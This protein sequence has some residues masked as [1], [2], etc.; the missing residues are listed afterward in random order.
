[1][2]SKQMGFHVL[3]NGLSVEKTIR[4]VVN[5]TILP[6]SYT[7]PNAGKTSKRKSSKNH[8]VLHFS[9]QHV[10]YNVAYKYIYKSDADVLHSKAHPNLQQ[11]CS[12]TKNITGNESLFEKA[13]VIKS[14][15]RRIMILIQ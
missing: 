14:K 5:I 10:G 4:L 7:I 6:L 11:I 13:K 1:M 2:L 12:L 3:H 15:L 8:I 9:A